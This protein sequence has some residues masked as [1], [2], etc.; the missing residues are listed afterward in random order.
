MNY[1]L[2]AF[3]LYRGFLTFSRGG[4][5]VA[6]IVVLILFIPMA[7]SSLNN[8]IK[9]TVA[10]L[11]LGTVSLLLFNKVNT[12]TNNQLV[13][14]YMGETPGTLSG[15]KQ[16]NINTITSYRTELA[17]TDLMMF[18]ENWMWG[19]GIGRAKDERPFYGFHPIVSHTEFTRLPGEQGIGGLGV[20]LALV[21]FPL[22]WVHKQKHT[23]WKAVASALFATAILTSF[24]SS[25]RTNTTLITYL[26]ASV[27]VCYSTNK[28]KDHE[29]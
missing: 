18:K 16:R 27:P 1:A 29:Q 9:F 17:R 3:L 21:L 4:M 22:W 11:L 25:M 6:A 20:V 10:I 28:N 26:L 23:I 7:I 8:F 13:L 2:V 24:H 12:L 19:V 15:T 5:V 14:R